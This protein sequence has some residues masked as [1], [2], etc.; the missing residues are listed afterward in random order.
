MRRTTAFSLVFALLAGASAAIPARAADEDVQVW[1]NESLA[2]PLSRGNHA[3]LDLSQRFRES[4]NQVLARVTI[5]RRLSP[6]V[7]IGGGAAQ[8]STI[9]SADEFRPHQQLT[10]T[11]GPLTLRTRV[12]QRFFERADRMELRL[13]QRIGVAVP[14]SDRLRAGLA[15]E[16]LYIAQSQDSAQGS[17]VDQWRANATMAR[18]LTESLEA[19]LG[20]LAILAPRDGAPDKLSHVAQVIL[21][22][23]R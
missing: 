20:Y 1:I 12:E 2:A 22:L 10:L 13:R 6:A 14:V 17:H 18:H 16:L 9:G 4:G 5:E 19:T 11:Y 3:T 7:V 23:R 8:V 21:T 15:G